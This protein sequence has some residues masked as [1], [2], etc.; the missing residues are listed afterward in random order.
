MQADVTLMV[1]DGSG[2]PGSTDNPV[3]VTLDNPDDM[4]KGVQLD[5]CDVD[6]F[7]SCTTCDTAERATDF[8]CSINEIDGGCCRIILVSLTGGSMEAGTGPIFTINYDVLEG[9]PSGECRDL[10]LNPEEVEIADEMGEPITGDVIT[11]S[12]EFCF[13]ASSSTTTTSQKRICA[14]K[15]IYSKNSEEVKILR[16]FR[17]Q[18]L[19][20]TQSGRELIRLYYQFSPAIMKAI[21]EDKGL[22]EKVK[23]IIDKTLPLIEGEAE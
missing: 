10:D 6:D 13:L 11:V 15:E 22:R 4:I 9:A 3:V 21:A 18:V 16:N 17:D 7:L 5:L 19:R 8:S 14:I 12:G 20:K 1:G 2:S 23:E